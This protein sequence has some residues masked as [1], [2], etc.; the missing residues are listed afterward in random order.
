LGG[1]PPACKSWVILG[2]NQH[3]ANGNYYWEEAELAE[4]AIKNAEANDI[5]LDNGTLFNHFTDDILKQPCKV[6]SAH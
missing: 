2:A 6:T 1:S 5:N 4:R 3:A